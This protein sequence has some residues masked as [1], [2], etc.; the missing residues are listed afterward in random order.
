MSPEVTTAEEL[1]REDPINAEEILDINK[2]DEL[3]KR[4]P[5]HRY[6]LKDGEYK[7]V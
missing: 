1:K 3:G 4:A 6:E 5:F 2:L 7:Q